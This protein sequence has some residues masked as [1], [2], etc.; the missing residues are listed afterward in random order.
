MFIRQ[1]AIRKTFELVVLGHVYYAQVSQNCTQ[2]TITYDIWNKS[3]EVITDEE[4]KAK[5][6]DEYKKYETTETALF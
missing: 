2:H 4:I 5:F 6:I 3:G 1:H